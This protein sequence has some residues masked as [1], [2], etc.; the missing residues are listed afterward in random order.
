MAASGLRVTPYL[1]GTAA[2]D[3]LAPGVYLRQGMTKTFRD[4]PI[5]AVALWLTTGC[6]GVDPGGVTPLGPCG[7]DNSCPSGSSCYFPLGSC[8]AKGQCVQD[9]PSSAPLCNAIEEVCGCGMVQTTGCGFPSGYASGPAIS[10]S[11][12]LVDTA[13]PPGSNVGPCGA[14]DEC[15]TGSS[16]VYPIG[17]CDAV[18]AC[19]EGEP[20]GT[21]VCKFQMDICGC[22]Q[23][24]ITGCGYPSG[25]ASLPST[26][27][28]C[29]EDGGP[30][31]PHD[32]G[33]VDATPPLDAMP[34]DAGP[35]GG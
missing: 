29:A 8:S 6:G 18:P 27:I 25:Y 10:G 19:I 3:V 17:K 35:G 20:A 21:P 32:A 1:A 26:G 23:L 11:A 28:G 30:P 7:A 14:K 12:C 2:R 5:L 16:C 24:A 34:L 33:P 22:G 4:L 31:P 13:P 15:P 9:Q